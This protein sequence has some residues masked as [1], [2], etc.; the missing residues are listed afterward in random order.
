MSDDEIIAT[1]LSFA[2]CFGWTPWYRSAVGRRFALDSRALKIVLFTPLACALILLAVLMTLAADDVRNDPK[3]IFM[4]LL[5]GVGWAGMSSLFF[6]TFGISIREDVAERHNRAAAIALAGALVGTTLAFAGANV[7]N[8]PGWWVVVICA[9]LATA[10]L[11]ALWMLIELTTGVNEWITVE[12]DRAT[13]LRFAGL[14]IALGL[15]LGRAVAGDWHSIDATLQDFWRVGRMAVLLAF[16]DIIVERGLQFMRERAS[17]M[18]FGV[19]PFLAYVGA[20]LWYVV[21]GLPRP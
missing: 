9:A 19:I 12:R 14:L 4:Y 7:G 13:A 16:A 21:V 10:A 20:A 17:W 1:F 6:G 18:T 5:M 3:Y 15:I 11:F 8:G 2:G